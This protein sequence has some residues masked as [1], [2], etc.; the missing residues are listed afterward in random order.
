MLVIEG[1]ATEYLPILF[2]TLL[3]FSIS[4]EGKGSVGY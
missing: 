2:E 4:T 3:K 1:L